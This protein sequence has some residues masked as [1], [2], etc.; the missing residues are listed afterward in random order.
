[1]IGTLTTARGFRCQSTLRRVAFD[2]VL[3]ADP[4][5]VGS[6]GPDARMGSRF[7]LSTFINSEYGLDSFWDHGQ[8]QTSRLTEGSATDRLRCSEV[9]GPLTLLRGHPCTSSAAVG[10]ATNVSYGFNARLHIAPATPDAGP[11][12]A[13][14]ASARPVLLSKAILQHPD[15]PL[16]WDIDG[17][18][19]TRRGATT[20][21]FSAPAIG[22]DAL[23]RGDRLWA[24]APRHHGRV[25]VAFVGGHVLSSADPRAEP[26]WDW[27]YTPE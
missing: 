24:P 22:D 21:H 3:F 4:M 10:P 15:V 27:A 2:F 13:Q 19:L 7:R 20:P 8:D 16:A 9:S 6:R 5:T 1:M 26:T 14:S 25:N 12:A 18:A 17:A 23:F 11:E